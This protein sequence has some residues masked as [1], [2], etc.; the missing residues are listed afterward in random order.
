MYLSYFKYFSSTNV[1]KMLIWCCWVCLCLWLTWLTLRRRYFLNTLRTAGVDFYPMLNTS[2]QLLFNVK[3]NISGWSVFYLS[4][5][6]KDGNFPQGSLPW[7]HDVT[8]T[9]VDVNSWSCMKSEVFCDIS[10]CRLQTKPYKLVFLNWFVLA[11]Q[12][13]WIS[14]SSVHYFQ[15]GG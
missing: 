12:A 2:I 8:M 4:I 10:S 13:E 3:I 15:D 9:F 14:I 11:N 7:R 1:D 6:E 5:S